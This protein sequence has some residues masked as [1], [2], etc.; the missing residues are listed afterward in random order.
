[1]LQPGGSLC[2]LFTPHSQWMGQWSHNPYPTQNPN[3]NP[4]IFPEGEDLNKCGELHYWYYKGFRECVFPVHSSKCCL[5]HLKINRTGWKKIKPLLY[6]AN[7][8]HNTFP[9]SLSTR[10][11]WFSSWVFP[12]RPGIPRLLQQWLQAQVEIPLLAVAS[13]SF[14]SPDQ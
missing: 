8:P 3:F 14:C 7:G 13:T 11:S 2:H 6:D 12:L 10:W 5:L 9:N 1:M 4:T